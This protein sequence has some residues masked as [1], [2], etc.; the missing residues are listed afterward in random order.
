MPKNSNRTK[1]IIDPKIQNKAIKISLPLCVSGP[2]R[3]SFGCRQN[4]SASNKVS[5]NPITLSPKSFSTGRCSLNLFHHAIHNRENPFERISLKGCEGNYGLKPGHA[6]NQVFR[7]LIE[8][9]LTLL[10]AGFVSPSGVRSAHPIT[11]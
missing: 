8:R 3:S 10:R 9:A 2:G 4:A 7:R 1:Q 11:G 6:E 5:K